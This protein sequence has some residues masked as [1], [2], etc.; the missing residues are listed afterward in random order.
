MKKRRHFQ[1]V[2]KVNT[3]RQHL[4]E[5]RPISDLCYESNIEPTQF[6]QWQK[7]FFENGAAAFISN[8]RCKSALT[9]KQKNELSARQIAVIKNR[10][11]MQDVLQGKLPVSELSHDINCDFS[12][13][14]L[15]VLVSNIL[16]KPLKIRNRGIAILAYANGIPVSQIA[17]FLRVTHTT[18][19]NHIDSYKKNGLTR[20]LHPGQNDNRKHKDTKY[21]DAVFKTLHSPPKDH[22]INRTSWKLSDIQSVLST[23]GILIGKTCISKIIKDAGFRYRKAK[24]VLTSNDPKYRVKIR[25]INK[26]L[27]SLSEKEKFFS[28]DEYGPF[29]IKLHG[30]KS[31]VKQGKIK[32]IPQFQKSKGSLIITGALELSTNQITHFYSKSK[33]T[34][35]MI[36]LLE[37]LVKKYAEEDSIFFLWDAASWHASKA[38]YRKVEEINLDVNVKPKVELA[39]LPTCAQFLNVIES[40]FS[41]MAKAILHNSDYESVKE[42]RVAID[43]YFLERNLHF[44]THPKRAGNKIW[45]QERSVSQFSEGNNC[46]DPKYR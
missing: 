28:I 39:P 45:G 19:D 23:Q 24:K 27:S 25:N 20:Y 2:D 34:G 18:V 17:N 13:E 9:Q 33:D 43:R 26:I 38:F 36:K 4:L 21:I 12:P 11:W 40:V 44:K 30:G 16:S 42:C 29:A 5:K 35:E 32:T 46:K 14:E 10:D 22:D 3:I 1:A 6:Y 8:R 31:L 7:M 37:I 15:N 41:G